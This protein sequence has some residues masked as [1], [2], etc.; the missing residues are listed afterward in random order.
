MGGIGANLI[1]MPCWLRMPRAHCFRYPKMYRWHYLR[2]A[3]LEATRVSMY[4]VS[5]STSA[6]S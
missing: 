5:G 4:E 3:H 2:E 1:E 6:N